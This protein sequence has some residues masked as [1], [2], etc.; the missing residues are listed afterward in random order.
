MFTNN[1]RTHQ[2]YLVGD[3]GMICGVNATTADAITPSPAAVTHFKTITSFGIWSYPLRSWPSYGDYLIAGT[4]VT[5]SLDFIGRVCDVET[6]DYVYDPTF[7][8][9]INVGENIILQDP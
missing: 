7:E 4:P 6:N 5:S 9:F 3:D 8:T 2:V 1:P